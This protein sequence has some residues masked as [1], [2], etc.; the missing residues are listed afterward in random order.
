MERAVKRWS[1]WGNSFADAC[2]S[3]RLVRQV[4][5]PGSEEA[6]RSVLYP[7]R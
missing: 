4:N 2:T 5:Q 3:V 6:V 7:N 1:T